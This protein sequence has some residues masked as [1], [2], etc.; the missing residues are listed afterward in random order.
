[1]LQSK[2]VKR[3]KVPKY[4]TLR[5]ELHLKQQVVPLKLC[6][7]NSLDS[8]RHRKTG[9]Q[10]E[11]IKRAE[12]ARDAAPPPPPPPESEMHSREGDR[13]INSI[14]HNLHAQSRTSEEV[15]A[16]IIPQYVSVLKI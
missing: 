6:H 5:L 15:L 7:S 11:N 1:M 2:G 14:C 10:K 13:R 16:Y 4:G 9:L 3:A 12:V 8:S